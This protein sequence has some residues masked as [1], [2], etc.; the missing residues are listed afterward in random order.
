MEDSRP[1]TAHHDLMRSAH[2]P[3]ILLH[4]PL[5]SRPFP[6]QFPFNPP[7]ISLQSPSIF[8]TFP[9]PFLK[10]FQNSLNIPPNFLQF[11]FDSSS[12]FVQHSFSPSEES[13]G[14]EPLNYQKYAKIRR[15]TQE[16]AKNTQNAYFPVL[17]P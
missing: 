17:N 7:S 16:Y 2:S 11:P 9:L 5:N 6:L 14:S 4:V 12:T 13:P 10:S 8:F 3:S 1:P 15:N